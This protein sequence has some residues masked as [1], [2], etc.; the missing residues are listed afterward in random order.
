MHVLH[1]MMIWANELFSS[2]FDKQNNEAG[3]KGQGGRGQWAG[4]I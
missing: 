3:N 4:V 2:R 1:I